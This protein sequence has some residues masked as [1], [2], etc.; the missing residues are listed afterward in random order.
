MQGT[1]GTRLLMLAL[2]RQ[3][4]QFRCWRNMSSCQFRVNLR[5]NYIKYNNFCIKGKIITL[6]DITH[7]KHVKKLP[8]RTYMCILGWRIKRKLNDEI[9][10]NDIARK[11]NWIFYIN[12]NFLAIHLI[13]YIDF[14]NSLHHVINLNWP[15]SW[16]GL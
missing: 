10:L 2:S 8:C 4:H 11:K 6:A 12:R 14:N 16:N 5:W 13:H 9:V 7:A 3:P 15:S 1:M